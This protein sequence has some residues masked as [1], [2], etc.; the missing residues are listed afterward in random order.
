MKKTGT[1]LTKVLALLVGGVFAQFCGKSKNSGTF[2]FYLSFTCSRQ[3]M[4]TRIANRSSTV[5]PNDNEIV[6]TKTVIFISHD[7]DPTPY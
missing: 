5:H 4:Y 6:L 3:T 2:L 7:C 1:Y